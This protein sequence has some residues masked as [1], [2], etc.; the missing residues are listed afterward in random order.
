MHV[1]RLGDELDL[2]GIPLLWLQPRF[3]QREGE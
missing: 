1:E 3:V 2:W